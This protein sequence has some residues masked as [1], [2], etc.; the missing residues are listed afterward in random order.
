MMIAFEFDI[1]LQDVFSLA[2]IILVRCIQIHLG[3]DIV[4]G[5]FGKWIRPVTRKIRGP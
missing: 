2:S 4:G 1:G 3:T 5:E